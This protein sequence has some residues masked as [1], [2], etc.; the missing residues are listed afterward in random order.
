MSCVNVL[1]DAEEGFE[2]R[3]EGRK[4]GKAIRAVR[5]IEVTGIIVES[6]TIDEGEAGGLL[7]CELSEMET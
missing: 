1:I 5:K 2:A 3:I 4:V 7:N 6:E